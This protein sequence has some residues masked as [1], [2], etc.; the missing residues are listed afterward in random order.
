MLN[1][2][3]K[4]L[5]FLRGNNYL[6]EEIDSFA[7]KFSNKAFLSIIGVTVLLIGI[8]VTV[9]LAQNP[10]IFFSKAANIPSPKS[11]DMVANLT[12]QLLQEKVK[13]TDDQT[14][15]NNILQQLAIK[16]KEALLKEINNPAKF[17]SHATLAS[18]RSSFP[19]NIQ[20]FIEEEKKFQGEVTVFTS[21]DFKKNESKI[22]YKIKNSDGKGQYNLY[23]V[24]PPKNLLSGSIVSATGLVLGS[25]MVVQSSG[26]VNSSSIKSIGEQKT[27]V[28]LVNFSN[29]QSKP[30]TADTMK[31]VMFGSNTSINNYYKEASYNKTN[32][33]GDVIDWLTIDA[34]NNGSC[35]VY[36][37]G[38]EADS[39]ATLKGINLNSFQR[40]I[41]VF[42]WVNGCNFS[43][44]ATLGGEP[45]K[46]WLVQGAADSSM[47]AHELGH[48]LGAAH[49]SLLLCGSNAVSDYSSCT[50]NEYGDSLDIMGNHT[51]VAPNI[52]HLN[53]PHKDSLGWID[54]SL[55]QTVSQ[56]G[57]YNLTPLET[58]STKKQVIKIYKKDTN[59]YYYL[60]FR[61]ATGFDQLLPQKIINGTLI[62]IWSGNPL[63]NTLLIDTT[64]NSVGYPYAEYTDAALLNGAT[65]TDSKNGI[66]I[67]QLNSSATDVSLQITFSPGTFTP[68]TT[69]CIQVIT[70]AVNPITGECR[71]FSTPCDVPSGWKKVDNCDSSTISPTTS[72]SLPS[73]NLTGVLS[74]SSSLV[75]NQA[76]RFT[77]KAQ[78]PALTIL[79]KAQVYA[80]KKD[81][82]VVSS[83]CPADKIGGAN[84]EWC[85]VDERVLSGTNQ[86]YTFNWVPPQTG[87]FYLALNIYNNKGNICTGNPFNI[88][89]GWSSCGTSGNLL[90]TINLCSSECTYIT[91][92]PT[93]IKNNCDTVR[94][95]RGLP[96]CH[97]Y[98]SS[99]T[100]H[101]GIALGDQQGK[102][103]VWQKFGEACQ[104]AYCDLCQCVN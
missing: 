29:D 37:W 69:F 18:Q 86:S 99:L 20:A 93:G 84:K 95:S 4:A 51:F 59:D 1:K 19:A 71:M 81:G 8:I 6:N 90:V 77:I 70:S 83:W 78:S 67:K 104:N 57:T 97:T 14:K 76:A 28:L 34:E 73:A 72:S 74:G 3:K 96:L 91:Y 26:T 7:F 24:N 11:T 40:I 63:T 39:K 75:V 2:F 54:Q 52:Y 80:A 47:L 48:N 53:A 21:D 9:K 50:I 79:T 42:P 43:G 44:L 88:P 55:I 64:P 62:H 5:L 61:K 92:D 66:T 15:K 27:V 60:E 68:T 103:S 65:F 87:E 49:A 13:K 17:L 98:P 33:S 32:F 16:R 30:F 12:S 58:T 102:C 56:S 10:Q 82:S 89:A 36:N 22:F 85:K 46:A 41:Y 35:D 23:F 45:S 38:D 100:C 25:E 31:Q 94:K 101:T